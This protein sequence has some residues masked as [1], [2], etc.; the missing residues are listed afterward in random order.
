MNPSYLPCRRVKNSAEKKRYLASDLAQDIILLLV[1]GH[2]LRDQ[3][4]EICMMAGSKES[5]EFQ[6]ASLET[7]KHMAPARMGV[8]LMPNYLISVNSHLEINSTVTYHC[9]E[10]PA[11]S[12]K[13]GMSFR[14]SSHCNEGFLNISDTIRDNLTVDNYRKTVS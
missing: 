13:I 2:Y 9:F 14:Q 10:E 4:F 7:L 5:P 12:R 1:D 6:G 3:A 11:L 8:T